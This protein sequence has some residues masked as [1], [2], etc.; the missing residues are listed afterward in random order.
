[1]GFLASGLLDCG[2]CASAQGEETKHKRQKH[3]IKH[4]IAPFG[5]GDGRR[6][7]TPALTL[8]LFALQHRISNGWVVGKR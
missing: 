1:M 8:F 4:R 3:C 7:L 5:D 2:H 6:S